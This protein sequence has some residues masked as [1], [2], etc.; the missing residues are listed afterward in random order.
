MSRT[1]PKFDFSSEWLHRE[2]ADFI[3]HK[4]PGH[5]LLKCKTILAQ[6]AA[7]ELSI[8]TTPDIEA[9]FTTHREVYEV[10]R[11]LQEIEP[12]LNI[13][14]RKGCMTTDNWYAFVPR[15][16][17]GWYASPG[18]GHP[19]YGYMWQPWSLRCPTRHI[20]IELVEEKIEELRTASPNCYP[21]YH[22][23]Y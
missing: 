8:I 12:G 1:L 6:R 19:C 15:Q 2:S 14:V 17:G 4:T 11:L 16:L 10:L 13:K 18:S 7:R 3:I 9:A 20:G 23:K 5:W 22:R 21:I